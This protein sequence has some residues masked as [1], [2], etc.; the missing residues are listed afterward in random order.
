MHMHIC[1]MCMWQLKSIYIIL[2]EIENAAA[3][4]LLTILLKEK[5]G[6]QDGFIKIVT[7]ISFV[8]VKKKYHMRTV[9]I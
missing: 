4:I 9:I 5:R 1:F 3:I 7:V 6:K 8:Y 2:I